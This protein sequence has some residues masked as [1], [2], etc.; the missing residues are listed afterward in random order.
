MQGR[1]YQKGR[2]AV[3]IYEYHCPRCEHTTEKVRKVADRDKPVECEA[4]FCDK[5]IP[6]V[7]KMS[8]TSFSLKGGGWYADGYSS[9]K[10]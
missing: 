10:P 3:P 6:P 2:T 5:D 9:K 8:I 1:T 4:P 7:R